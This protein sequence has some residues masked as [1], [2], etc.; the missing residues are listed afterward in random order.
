MFSAFVE[1][2]RARKRFEEAKR[3][4][5]NAKFENKAALIDKAHDAILVQDFAAGPV[6]LCGMPSAERLVRV[7]RRKSLQT[8][9]D[10]I[11]YFLAGRR[12][13]P[14]RQTDSHEPRG[15]ER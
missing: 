12:G 9:H 6:G 15:M 10:S 3:N 8:G 14:K 13:S 5:R 1:W 11:G 7:G 4:P 2:Y